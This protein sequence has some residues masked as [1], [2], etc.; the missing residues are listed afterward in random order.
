MA[1]ELRG[2]DHH[3]TPVGRRHEWQQPDM[4]LAVDQDPE[5][6]HPGFGEQT[7]EQ[8]QLVR[9]HSTLH[10]VGI[11]PNPV[12]VPVSVSVPDVTVR[13]QTSTKP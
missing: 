3:R 2:V 9:C 7:L 4:R 5:G 1:G 11:L 12:S 8:T 13:C 6:Q 10:L